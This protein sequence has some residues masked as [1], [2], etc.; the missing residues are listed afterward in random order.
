MDVENRRYSQVK[1]KTNH[2]I[3]S[4]SLVVFLCLNIAM[5]VVGILRKDDCPI[6]NKIP[7]YLL[8]AGAVG[9]MSKILPF[10]NRKFDF[11]CVDVLV[12]LLYLFEFVW[13]I[14]GSVWIYSIYP[15]NFDPSA[16]EFCNKTVYLLSFWLLTLHWSD[17]V[18]VGTGGTAGIR[19]KCRL[20]APVDLN[21]NLSLKGL[22]IGYKVF[23]NETK[24]CV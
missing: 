8:V 14:L 13:I 20:W 24:S 21:K 16:G 3:C 4:V 10:I 17:I 1:S 19:P 2:P 23:L 7:L 6:Q 11:C 18:F 5:L 12:S 22:T 9:L 15:P